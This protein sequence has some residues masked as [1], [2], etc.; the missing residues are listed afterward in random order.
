MGDYSMNENIKRTYM[1]IDMK[2]FYASVECAERGLNP[3][4][5]N[6]VVADRNRGKNALCL[7]ITPKLKAEGVKN[8]CR[9]LDIPR[10]IEYITA[11][12]RMKLYIEY[13]AD[14]YALYLNYFAPSAI[15]VYSIDE[16]FIDVTDYLN[17]NNINATL[18][19]KKLMNEI[20]LKKHIPSTV[21]I[22][23]NLYLAKVAL[24]ISAKHTRDHIA[25]LDEEFY[26]KTLWNHTPITDFWQIAAGKARRLA[27]YS[28]YDMEGVAKAPHKLLEKLFGRDWEL[29]YD[30]AWG[31]ESCLMQDIK[32]YKSKSHSVSFSQILPSDYI[33]LDA[34]TVMMEMA[35][36]GSLEL[37]KRHL[38]THKVA[39]YVGYSCEQHEPTGGTSKMSV[40]TNLSSIIL[41]YVM[42]LFDRTTAEGYLIRRLGLSFEDVCD[43]A[44]E[45]YNLFTDYEAI[46]KEKY[47]ERTVLEIK[48]KFGKNAILRGTNFK[49]GATQRERNGFI[50]GHKA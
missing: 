30:H 45:G 44:C 25:Y 42:E 13:S 29:L 47:R 32:N 7:A 28:I 8:R 14:I 11:M 33:L 4:E 24:D 23:T 39:I 26:R 31:R 40:T 12:P 38:S 48:A 2:S 5:T 1:C 9:L 46:E 50:G 15:H 36:Y 6:L 41:P 17:L 35:M 37:I 22:G 18:L 43:E 20:A 16:C 3:F 10:H 21:G 49:K 19:A 27:K 34:R